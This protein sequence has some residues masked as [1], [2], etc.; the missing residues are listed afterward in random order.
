[1]TALMRGLSYRRMARTSASVSRGLLRTRSASSSLLVTGN[2]WIPNESAPAW[3]RIADLT[4][5]LS[6]W[7][8]ETTAMIAVTATMLPS[9]VMKERSF[10]LQIATM[11]ILAPITNLCNCHGPLLADLFGIDLEEIAFHH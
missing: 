2:C 6:P 3:A 9:T 11:A 5:A 8:S 4:D 7:M 10:A 1:M